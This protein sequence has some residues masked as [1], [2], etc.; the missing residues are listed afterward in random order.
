MNSAQSKVLLVS[1]SGDAAGAQE[2]LRAMNAAGDV[3]IVRLSEL[4]RTARHLFRQR[5]SR[6]VIAGDPPRDEIGYGLT[7]LIALASRARE[8]LLIDLTTRSV[9]RTSLLRY[10]SGALPF[11]SA[12][13]VASAAA[14]GA[15]RAMI[16]LGAAPSTTSRQGLRRV[17]YLRPSVG[18]SSPV[19]GSVTHAHEVIRAL[20][21]SN[22]EV[23]AFT[24]D[25]SIAQAACSDPDRACQWYVAKTP[26]LVKAL[27]ASAG[28]GSDVVLSRAALR[29]AQLSD[30]IYQRHARFSV[31]G[32]LLARASGKP[33]FLEYNGSEEFV[34]RFW[35]PTTLRR[36]LAACESVALGAATKVFVVSEIDRRNLLARGVESERIVVNPNGVAIERFADANGAVIR[37]RWGLAE[38]D[39]V[40]GFIGTFGPWHGAPVLARAFSLVARELP[41]AKLLLVGDGPQLDDTRRELVSAGVESRTLFIGKVGP[42]D[43]PHYL[44]ACD[45]LAS[46]HVPLPGGVEFFGSPTK[47]FEYMAAGKAIIASEL[48][49]IADVLEHGRTAWLVP[50]GDAD[51]LASGISELAM[52][53]QLREELATR[54]REEAEKYTWLENAHRIIDAFPRQA[55]ADM[56]V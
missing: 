29:Y 18:S 8:I 7:A 35:N 30:V 5:A 48:G 23:D 34:G 9:R 45:L 14:V 13:L 15:Q 53:P 31:V 36:Q 33:L 27:P 49:Q 19:G 25:V 51:A 32:A 52:S 4:P 37:G 41:H 44:D 6:L 43:V 28:F 56:K 12:Q 16:K 50:P 3:E 21:A 10:L 1:L 2:A 17:L 40:I 46:P 24:T 11:G 22:I 42:G 54:V 20:R 39:F 55:L 47:L 26:R 38:T